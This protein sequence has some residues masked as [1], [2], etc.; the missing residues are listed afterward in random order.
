MEKHS[1]HTKTH[2][3]LTLNHQLEAQRHYD[4]TQVSHYS[5]LTFLVFARENKNHS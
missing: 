5:P 2:T 4:G 1:N 3:H